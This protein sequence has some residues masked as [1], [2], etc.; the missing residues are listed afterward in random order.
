MNQQLDPSPRNELCKN[1]LDP[2]VE[3]ELLAAGVT[4]ARRGE[5][6]AGHYHLR[7][8]T[9]PITAVAAQVLKPVKLTMPGSPHNQPHDA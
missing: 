4:Y 7:T 9:T 6:L 8:A 3:S 2:S 1:I 5:R